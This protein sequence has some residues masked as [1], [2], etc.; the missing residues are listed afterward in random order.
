MRIIS[1]K[2]LIF[3]N[4]VPQKLS[5]FDFELPAELIADQPLPERDASRMLVLD[6]TRKTFEDRKFRDVA[7]ILG[8][9][10]V[11]VM[12]NTRVFPAR[13]LGRTDTGAVVE[14]LLTERVDEH[15]WNALAKPARRLK[16]GK[17]IAFSPK[18]R[19][20]VLERKELGTVSIEFDAE[21]ELEYL[22]DKVGRTPVPP[23]IQRSIA[24]PD[25]D[26]ERYQTV[27]AK[28]SGAIAAPTAGLHFSHRTLAE[29]RKR[30]VEIAE[31]TLHVGYGTFEPVRVDNLN[32]HR[33][34]PERYSI[35]AE[36]ANVIREAMNENRRIV[37]VG[38]TS[39][40]AL[41]ACFAEFGEIRECRSTAQLT[42]TPG[43]RFRVVNGLITNFHLPKSSLLVLVSTFAGHKLIMSAYYH[44]IEQRYRFYSYGDC[45]FIS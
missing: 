42:V 34:L 33:V 14:L 29:L 22:I 18:L 21:G 8:A 43:Y 25:T 4:F 26:R 30:G 36:V 44:A 24:G 19:A 5:D 32:E 38:T 23:Y 11:L 28:E 7:N 27:Y 1:N 3:N 37:A 6:R 12:N 13:L 9:G 35:E 31:I 39:T 10:D 17:K 15:R 2:S 45:M 41:E 16:P 40:R 20:F